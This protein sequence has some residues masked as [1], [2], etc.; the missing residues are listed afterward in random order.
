MTCEETLIMFIIPVPVRF[1]PGGRYYRASR[2]FG[3]NKSLPK[4]LPDIELVR[5]TAV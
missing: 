2:V 3:R 5:F 1:S 4:W